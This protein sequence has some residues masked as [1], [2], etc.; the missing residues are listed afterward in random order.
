MVHVYFLL[1]I[2]MGI[3]MAP[4]VHLRKL[5]GEKATGMP[6]KCATQLYEKVLYARIASETTGH[7]KVESR[8][9]TWTNLPRAGSSPS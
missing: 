1:A 8:H 5:E 9:R 3:I 2:A 6:E 4:L 7:G